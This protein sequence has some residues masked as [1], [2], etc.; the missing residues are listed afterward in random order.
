MTMAEWWIP[1][2]LYLPVIKCFIIGL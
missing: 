1:G 2:Y